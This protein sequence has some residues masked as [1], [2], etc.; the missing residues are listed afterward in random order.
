M[1]KHLW[2]AV[3]ALALGLAAPATGRAG[4]ITF[5]EPF[6]AGVP[7]SAPTTFA[8]ASPLT[9]LYAPMGV[10]F[11]GPDA[12]SG[13]VILNDGSAFGFADFGVTAHSGSNF[14]AFNRNATYGP[15]F[16]IFS[17]P[18]GSA[19]DPETISFDAPQSQVSIW[20][21]GGWLPHNFQMQAFDAGGNLLATDTLIT[22]GWSQLTVSGS[23]IASVV[24]TETGGPWDAWVYDD[25]SFTADAGGG[26]TGVVDPSGDPK[27]APEPAGLVLLGLGGLGFAGWLRRRVV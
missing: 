12:F 20:A 26:V 18:G 19:S 3:A 22:Q 4:L 7:N 5:D 6:V 15:P 27:G 9:Q 8:F 24:L 17:F 10:H 13:G 23:G 1:R 25:L 21:A 11:A 2:P 16:P 14:L